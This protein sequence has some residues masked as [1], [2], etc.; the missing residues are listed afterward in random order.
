MKT[1]TKEI[2]QEMISTGNEKLMEVAYREYPELKEVKQLQFCPEDMGAIEGFYITTQGT[3][4]YIKYTKYY[5]A[6][7][8][9]KVYP[10][11][12]QALRY[13]LILP[14]LLQWVNRANG[15]NIEDWCDWNEI[16]IKFC[17]SIIGNKITNDKFCSLNHP[18]VFKTAEI[19]DLFKKQHKDLLQAYEDTFN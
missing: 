8:L 14:E 7:S 2:A 1:L 16:N 9:R 19:R 6:K 17:L 5:E 11:E 18:L 10:T 15:E 4:E 13:G 3:I 12:K